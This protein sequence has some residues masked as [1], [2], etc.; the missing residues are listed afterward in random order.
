MAKVTSHMT[1][2]E[3][4]GVKVEQLLFVGERLV[5]LIL[6]DMSR[7]GKAHYP[8]RFF[9]VEI[10]WRALSHSGSEKTL[11]IMDLR[12][13][14]MRGYPVTG[15][16]HP[17]RFAYV[18]ALCPLSTTSLARK[19]DGGRS[20]IDLEVG[21]AACQPMRIVYHAIFTSENAVEM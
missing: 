9:D 1:Y 15:V 21:A 7:V 6:S 5:F 2:Q 19:S 10:A 3:D 13:C 8:H 17:R 12:M 18:C 20:T 14:Y 11:W 16:H 4:V